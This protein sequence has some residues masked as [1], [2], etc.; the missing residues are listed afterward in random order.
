MP[1]VSIVLPTYNGQRYLRESIDSIIVQTYKD[2]ELIIVNDCSTD[3]TPKIIA[4]YL[5]KDFRIRTVNNK[6]NQKLPKSLNIGFREAKGEYLTWTSD[7][8][9]YLSKA[10]ERMVCFL[11]E[12]KNVPMVRAQMDVVNEYGE[13]IQKYI[14]YSDID[15]YF[16]DCVGACFMYRKEVISK[17]GEYDP[18]KF[19]I[20]D[21][22]YWMRILE[23]YGRI[24][25]ISEVL[26]KY[27]EH[28]ASLT[29]AKRAFVKEQLLKY[30][31]ANLEKILIEL[32]ERPERIA[33]MY[34]EFIG[35]DFE[36][37]FLE[38]ASEVVE[39]LSLL[40]NKDDALPYIIWGAGEFGKK[41]A[42]VLNGKID[43][44]ADSNN[45]K[46]GTI[47]E[48]YKVI[49]VEEMIKKANNNSI[50]I[51]V[52]NEKVYELLKYL[53]EKGIKKCNI[54]QRIS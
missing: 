2:W 13:F 50:C 37:K 17:V 51:A 40:K 45:K 18:S 1:K 25:Q 5:E 48:G 49:S 27:R 33:Q 47:F 16:N 43:C 31:M 14:E 41:A 30:R 35:S 7:D 24:G 44:Y 3:E 21:Y 32:K 34:C 22:E 54:I 28:T 26:Y 38:A 29:S 8:N 53:Y 4:E 11:D 42:L 52:G 9:M 36:L 39:E 6:E 46:V 19:C 12:N 20:E 10:L 23:H 15:M